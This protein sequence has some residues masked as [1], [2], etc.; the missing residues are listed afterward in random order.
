MPDL[1]SI[2]YSTGG[3]IATG[4]IVGLI[5]RRLIN[6]FAF[7]TGIQIVFFT[8]LDYISVI[9]IN[10]SGLQKAISFVEKMITTLSVPD[11]AETME[12]YNAGGIIGGFIL[13][14]LFGFY[15]L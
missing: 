9:D 5:A 4:A 2:L 13:G 6:V 8:Y 3:A 10:W 12:V 7:A 1:Y 14:V 15:K 11:N